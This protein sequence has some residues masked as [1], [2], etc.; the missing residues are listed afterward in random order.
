MGIQALALIGASIYNDD[1]DFSGEIVT[2][3]SLIFTLVSIGLSVAEYYLS[4]NL[5]ESEKFL[6]VTFEV[7]SNDFTN[8]SRSKFKSDNK[9]VNNLARRLKI[10]S[11]FIDRLKPVQTANGAIFQLIIDTR[12]AV[13]QSSINKNILADVCFLGAAVIYNM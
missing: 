12:V 5:L 6:I 4:K 3:L 13:T 10:D 2:I 7:L 11:S 8:M 9:F 1:F